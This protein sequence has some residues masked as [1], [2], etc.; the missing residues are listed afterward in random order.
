[1]NQQIP[2]INPVS[3]QLLQTLNRDPRL[4][5]VETAV[6]ASSTL[7]TAVKHPVFKNKEDKKLEKPKR[8]CSKHRDTKRKESSPSRSPSKKELLRKLHKKPE[9]KERSP[10]DEKYHKR[11]E[12]KKIKEPET[13]KKNI[14]PSLKV[15]QNEIVTANNEILP[16][17]DDKLLKAIPKSDNSN[18]DLPIIEP[19]ETNVPKDKIVISEVI[20]E[21]EVNIS[22]NITSE[23]VKTDSPL[24]DSDSLK[25]LRKYMQTMKKSPEPSTAL[26]VDL[27]NDSDN[28]RAIKSNQSKIKMPDQ[29]YFTIKFI[30]GDLLLFLNKLHHFLRHN[31]R[32]QFHLSKSPILTFFN[33]YYYIICL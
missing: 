30:V 20:K 2:K 29:L 15:Q 33:F 22:S 7:N 4:R 28:I 26:L 13:K 3:T 16:K 25:R 21:V 19:I 17:D 23:F 27:K 12:E 8:D 1:M 5:K 32:K 18:K 24:E 9:R 6:K 10:R 31:K 11:R 14:T